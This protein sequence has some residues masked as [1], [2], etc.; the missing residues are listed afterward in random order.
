[1]PE[2]K[3]IKVGANE[4]RARHVARFRP[5]LAIPLDETPD[6]IIS[7]A[8]FCIRNN[9]CRTTVWRKCRTGRLPKPVKGGFLARDLVA[10]LPH[11]AGAR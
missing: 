9:E 5:L 7:I 11:L 10:A 3:A 1:M 8:E 4:R 6:R 2:R